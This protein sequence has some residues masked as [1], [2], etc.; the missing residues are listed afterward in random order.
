MAATITM[1]GCTGTNAGTQADITAI[2]YRSNDSV[3]NDS[4]NPITIPSSG[5]NHSYEKWILWEVDVAPDN[6]CTN[7]KYWGPGTAPGTG[8]TVFAGTTATGVTPVNTDST[9]ATTQQDTNYSSSG[10]SLAISGTLAAIDDETDYL[11]LQL[12][13]ESTATQGD[14]TQQTY[15][16]S[17]DEN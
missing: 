1:R 16:Y 6:Q 14:M 17:Y 5:T 8:L 4:N 7:F 12:D 2:T 11:V 13:V 3:V 10:S 15:Y 9:V